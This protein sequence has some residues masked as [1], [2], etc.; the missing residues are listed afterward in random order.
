MIEADDDAPK[1]GP[2]CTCG[3][4]VGVTNI[5]ML[6]LRGPTP[7]KGWGCVVC[8]LPADGAIVVLCDACVERPVQSV[9]DGYP[10]DGK[11]VSVASLP[12]DV[13]DHDAA[14]HA[15]DDGAFV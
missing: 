12:D 6:P 9:C 3:T 8:G 2:C 11:R 7:G 13:F 4:T 1:L 10:K 5:L 15:A 14:K